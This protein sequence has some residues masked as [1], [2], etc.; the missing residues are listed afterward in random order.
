M[1]REDE[2]GPIWKMGPSLQKDA[3]KRPCVGRHG[4]FFRFFDFFYCLI[5]KKKGFFYS[6]DMAYAADLSAKH[7]VCL[8]IS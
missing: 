2:A 8:Q 7:S 1:C 3:L 6:S 5:A 4:D